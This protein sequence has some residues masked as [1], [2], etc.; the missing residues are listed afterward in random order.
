MKTMVSAST[1]VGLCGRIWPGGTG[2]RGFPLRFTRASS[3]RMAGHC[4]I[5][6]TVVEDLSRA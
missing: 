5:S 1:F 6:L 2:A 3:C 4:V